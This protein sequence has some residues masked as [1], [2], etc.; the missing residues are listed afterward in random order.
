MK[1]LLLVIALL[2]SA[3]AAAQT[4][5]RYWPSWLP[6]WQRPQPTATPTPTPTPTPTAEPAE[7]P[8]PVSAEQRA[9]EQ[10]ALAIQAMREGNYAIAYYH[11]LPLA[12]AGDGEAQFGIGWMYHN[13]YGLVID[14]HK[15]LQ[16]W[17][18]AAQQGHLDAMFA[19]GLLYA[20]GE[21][22]VVSDARWAAD[23][24]L[25]AARADH[26]EAR[27]MLRELLGRGGKKKEAFTAGWSSEDWALFGTPLWV[28]SERANFRSAIGLES[29]VIG[30]LMRDTELVE[31][32]RQGQWV[33]VVVPAKG[34]GGW[35]HDSLVGKPEATEQ[36]N[37]D[38]D[39]VQGDPVE[40]EAK[41][42]KE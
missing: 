37:G 34:S 23:L 2:I 5:Q 15:T 31:I 10:R 19:L 13:G 18:L 26:Q 22:D 27:S 40:A 42:A 25:K 14:D 32:S 8:E 35:I 11:W 21:L 33:E 29:Q 4:Q 41:P 16:W 9:A 6:Y 3:S 1:P 38:P 28:T 20:E 39:E 36:E 7:T 24:Y 17:S 30:V 12:E